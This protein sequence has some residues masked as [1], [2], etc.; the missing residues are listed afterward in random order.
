VKTTISKRRKGDPLLHE[1]RNSKVSAPT[2]PT[3]RGPFTPF[4][5]SR[6]KTKFPYILSMA[7]Y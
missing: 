3:T 4:D 2:L 7:N 1:L 5:L 6:L